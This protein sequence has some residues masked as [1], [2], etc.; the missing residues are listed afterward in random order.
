MVVEFKEPEHAFE[1]FPRMGSTSTITTD[2]KIEV[3]E[4]IVKHDWQSSVRRVA[5]QLA[6]PT[7]TVYEIMSSHLGMKKAFDKMGIKIALTYSKC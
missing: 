2:E 1:D 7:T 4:R 6:I 5:Y 3:V